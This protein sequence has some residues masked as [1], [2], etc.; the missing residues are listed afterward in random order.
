MQDLKKEKKQDGEV[1][2]RH[3][4][5]ILLLQRIED[6]DVDGTWNEVEVASVVDHSHSHVN[7][8]GK[9]KDGRD[10]D[11]TGLTETEVGQVGPTG[12]TDPGVVKL[13]DQQI[14]KFL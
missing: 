1:L 6:I 9:G 10:P 5:R 2:R 14:K 8:P 12:N 4:N 11:L 7:V 13:I 3:L